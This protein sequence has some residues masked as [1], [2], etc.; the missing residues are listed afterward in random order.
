MKPLKEA[1][2]F[3]SFC[4]TPSIQSFIE[5]LDGKE[6]S[7]I[8]VVVGYVYCYTHPQLCLRLM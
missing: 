3:S 2:P 5:A 1:M 8:A 6:T 7:C 4:Y